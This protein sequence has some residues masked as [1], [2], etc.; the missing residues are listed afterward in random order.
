[1][2]TAS[3]RFDPTPAYYAAEA[4][5][6]FAATVDVDMS[7]LY[8]PFLAELTPGAAILDAGCGSGRDARAFRERGYA[9]TATEPSPA[10][11]ALAEAH[12]GLPVA[13]LR[14]QD[15]DWHARFDGI[16]ACASLLHVPL[17]ELPDVLQRLARALRAGGS[18]YASFKYGHG[19]RERGG[20]RFTDL[21]EAGL[22]GLLQQV[23]RLAIIASWITG[24]CRPGREA[25]QWLN[26]LMRA[27]TA[28]TRSELAEHAHSGSAGSRN[29]PPN[30]GSRCQRMY[31]S[32][33]F[34][35][36][37]R[38]SSSG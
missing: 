12:C 16:W 37:G 4:T 21:D 15:L 27:K 6:F 33:I 22:A 17:A 30:V 11:A 19:E 36:P 14:F 5:A 26:S 20:R 25:E 2:S 3:R 9:V 29:T 38:G 10:L 7:S 24:D 18:L 13:R 34:G 28:G 23:P 1:V 8:A 35:W 31:S 32:S